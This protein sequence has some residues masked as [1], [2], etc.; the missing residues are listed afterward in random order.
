[1]LYTVNIGDF[2][3]RIVALN[4]SLST[5]I[6]K[7]KNHDA[8]WFVKD[9]SGTWQVDP[10][11]LF[12]AIATGSDLLDPTL[13]IDAKPTPI[14]KLISSPG[15]VPRGK[16]TLTPG[17]PFPTVVARPVESG[18]AQEIIDGEA[19]VAYA[20]K[21]EAHAVKVISIPCTE[22]EARILRVRL[23]VNRGQDLKGKSLVASIAAALEASP[24]L[25]A[26]LESS[27]KDKHHITQRDCAIRLFA[28]GSSSTI[29]RALKLLKSKSE[30]TKAVKQPDEIEA[31][32]STF[33]SLK[34]ASKRRDGFSLMSALI[35]HKRA[36]D[37]ALAEQ[38]RVD[39]ADLDVTLSK[40]PPAGRR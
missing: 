39:V 4:P 35:A 9:P 36:I 14:S 3:A 8:P 38:L 20:R 18:A 2:S 10:L 15:V 34:M 26:R 21:F 5:A 37:D 29:N 33:H 12:T 23:N 28:A 6:G 25:L 27:T 16:F 40:F 22:V 24:E 32:R 7:L 19:Y 17:R 13:K 31:I 1:M 11:H 30:S